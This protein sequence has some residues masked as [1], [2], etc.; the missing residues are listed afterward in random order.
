MDKI[1]TITSVPWATKFYVPFYPGE[2]TM[3]FPGNSV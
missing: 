2:I 3:I 1:I